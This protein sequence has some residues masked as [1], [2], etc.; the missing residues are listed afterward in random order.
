MPNIAVN[1]MELTMKYYNAIP[2]ITFD[3]IDMVHQRTSGSS[4]KNFTSNRK[5]FIEGV[6]YFFVTL[7]EYRERFDKDYLKKGGNPELLKALFT[8][9]GYY[10]LAKTFRD[11]LSWDVQR[12]LSRSYFNRN[13][14][15]GTVYDYLRQ[16]VDILESHSHALDAL[17]QRTHEIEEIIED[18]V[19][20][21]KQLEFE[22]ILEEAEQ[23][24][25]TPHQV[26]TKIG[27]YSENRNPHVQLVN[28]L[29]YQAGLKVHL[30][31]EYEDEHIRIKQVIQNGQVR[32]VGFDIYYKPKALGLIREWFNNHKEYA[33]F[34]SFYVKNSK[35][36]KV[37]ELKERGYKIGKKNYFIA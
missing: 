14:Q 26:A 17:A 35:Y 13:N 30:K 20:E 29:A 22:L 24:L 5:H 36:H 25:F 4:R 18:K 19:T 37:G 8:E 11:P 34:E 12:A 1:G 31:E 9:T 6:D 33:Y 16:I 28:A 23:K 2:V 27:L 32:L 21:T 15:N 3:E 7:D 10:L